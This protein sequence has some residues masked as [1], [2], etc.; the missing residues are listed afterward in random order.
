[1]EI[2]SEYEAV[3]VG[4]S[5]GATVALAAALVTEV[6]VLWALEKVQVKAQGAVV[7]ASA[8]SAKSAGTAMKDF[9]MAGWLEVCWRFRLRVEGRWV[10]LMI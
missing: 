8:L 2:H 5:V 10:V 6:Q 1:V 3:L 9:I 4:A 7:S